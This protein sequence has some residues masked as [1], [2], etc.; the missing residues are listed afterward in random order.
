MGITIATSLESS[1]PTKQVGACIVKGDKVVSVEYNKI[2]KHKQGKKQSV[3]DNWCKVR[4]DKGK[5]KYSY[6]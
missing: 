6:V 2:P 1:D 5:Q 4:H 3:Y